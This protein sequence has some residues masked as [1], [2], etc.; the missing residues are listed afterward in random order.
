[1]IFGIY[2]TMCQVHG[3]GL[4]HMITS[5]ILLVFADKAEAAI[6]LDCCVHT[7][8]QVRVCWIPYPPVFRTRVVPM[9]NAEVMCSHYHV[10]FGDEGFI[11]K[12]TPTGWLDGV[13]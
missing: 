2:G 7:D 9:T 12:T 4:S 3:V 8:E 11:Q 13:P 1:M 5:D 6:K 10:F